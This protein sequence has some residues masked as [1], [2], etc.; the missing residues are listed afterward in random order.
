MSCLQTYIAGE[1]DVEGTRE[2]TYEEEEHEDSL[3]TIRLVITS[4]AYI[5]GK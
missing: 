1:D 4:G 3:Q 5:I 2:G